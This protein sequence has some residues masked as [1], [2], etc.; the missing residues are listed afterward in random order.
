LSIITQQLMQN[1]EFLQHYNDT[2]DVNPENI[3]KYTFERQVVA[4]VRAGFKRRKRLMHIIAGPRQIGKSVASLQI[5]AKWQ[6]PVV[7][8]SADQPVPPG[9]EWIHTHWE[10]A[11]LKVR[12]NS[13]G[14]PSKVLLV[15]DE[16]QKVPGWSEVIKGLWDKEQWQEHH[17]ELILL[18]SSTLLLQKG[19]TE[20]LAGRVYL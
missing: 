17:I 15:L 13:S 1:D 3:T 5:A 14:S 2:E 10:L 7:I 6:G 11:I 19:M 18:G 9:P 4:Q 20:S 8:A 12:E 16:I